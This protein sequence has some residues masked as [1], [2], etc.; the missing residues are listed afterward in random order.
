MDDMVTDKIAQRE[1]NTL[2]LNLGTV[3]L[4]GLNDEQVRQLRLI[5]AQKQLE[6]AAELAEKKIKLD[7]AQTE[8]S[9]AT[10]VVKMVNRTG[11]NY[12]IKLKAQTA[13]GNISI[14]ARKVGLW[15]SN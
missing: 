6:L 9:L 3:Q 8:V 11:S 4:D 12:S 10:S 7:V 15:G 13:T 14:N 1:F 2:A 5:L